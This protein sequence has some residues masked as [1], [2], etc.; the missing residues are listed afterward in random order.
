MRKVVLCVL[1]IGALIGGPMMA[2]GEQ[3]DK[4]KKHPKHTQ[5]TGID[6]EKSTDA[7][8]VVPDRNIEG[9]PVTVYSN[10][11]VSAELDQSFEE[12]LVATVNADGTI[13]MTC[14]HGLPLATKHV[15]S[16]TSA[17]K[18]PAPKP[19]AK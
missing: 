11:R 18:Q 4:A 14:V 7:L 2:S 13:T 8:T 19:E 1:A 15:I 3:S 16:A 6:D 5:D 10:G 12:A 9:V 17:T